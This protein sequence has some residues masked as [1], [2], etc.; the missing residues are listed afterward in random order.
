MATVKSKETPLSWVCEVI[1]EKRKNMIRNEMKKSKHKQT[2]VWLGLLLLAVLSACRHVQDKDGGRI[3]G[4]EPIFQNFE[5]VGKD[6]IYVENPLPEG[7]FYSPILQGC[8]PDPSITR[9]GDDYYLVTS[10]FVMFPGVPIFHSKDLVNWKQIGH[11]LERESQLKVG[12]AGISMGVY[13]PDILY[14]PHNDTFYLI[15]TQ[16]AGG[17][18]NIVVKTKDPLQGN[19]SDPIKLNFDGIDP[20]LFFDDDGKAY[21]VHNDAPD[22]GKELYQGHRVIKV[23]DYDVEKDQVIAGTD[24]IIVDGGVDISK[25]PIWI[26]A[27]HVYKRYGK[28][29]LMCAEGGTGANHSEVIFV[30]D[31][32]RGPYKPA[33]K[34]PILSQRHLDKSRPNP[35]EWA[36]HADLVETPNG[37]WYGVFL[38]IRPNEK[39]RVNTGRETF[40]L[41]VDW[42]GEW[43]VFQGGMEPL[44]PSIEMPRGA[45]NKTGTDDFF[46]SGNF[47]FVDNFEGTGLDDRWIAL[48]GPREKFIR[49]SKNGLVIKPFNVNIKALKPISTLFHRQQHAT[50]SASVDMHYKPETAGDLAGL[51]CVQSEAFNYVFGVTKSGKDYYLVLERTEKGTSK[52]I[53]QTRLERM[54]KISLKVTANGDNYRFYYAMNNETFENLGGTVSGDILSTDVAGGF[55]GAMIGLYATSAND[56]KVE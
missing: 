29:Y 20:A 13:A 3:V 19:W 26:E 25:K 7:H 54:G 55:T 46:P 32:P 17:F 9:K 39:G 2:A 12:D 16:F 53:A 51:A 43:P 40:I 1:E 30:S 24:K 31:S 18:G 34:N 35:V 44:K 8:Y 45:E 50:F 21:V 36:G 52:L 42:S 37:D 10:S 22:E 28:Y 27:P 56:I 33:E 47:T 6:E 14:N 15:T 49:K 38:A 5:Y 41:P 4:N 23:W 11:V 48:R